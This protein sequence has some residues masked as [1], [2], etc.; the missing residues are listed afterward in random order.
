MTPKEYAELIV[1]SLFGFQQYLDDV[2]PLAEA[3]LA[4]EKRL[5]AAMEVVEAAKK[6]R[7]ASYKTHH[8]CIPLNEALD[9]FES[10]NG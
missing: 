1:K 3:Y 9:K 6:A 5:A 8:D 4:T 2:K 10:A 7:Y